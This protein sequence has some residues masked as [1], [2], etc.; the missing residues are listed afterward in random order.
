MAQ[1]LSI[2]RARVHSPELLLLDEPFTGLDEPSAQRLSHRLEGLANEGHALVL[3]THEIDRAAR[4]AQTALLLVE[5]KVK[6]RVAA[7][8]MSESV[9]RAAYAEALEAPA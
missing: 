3:A 4:L 5:G 2:A 9:L 7:E 1:R 8:E 6:R